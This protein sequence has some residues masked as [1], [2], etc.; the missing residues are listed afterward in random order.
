MS[1][2]APRQ[3]TGHVSLYDLLEAL[4]RLTG[5]NAPHYAKCALR[6]RVFRCLRDVS[7]RRRS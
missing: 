3:A 4:T 6:G 7:R 2:V 5:I 1:E